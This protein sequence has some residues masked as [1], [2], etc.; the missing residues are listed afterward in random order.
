MNSTKEKYCIYSKG[1]FI[2]EKEIFTKEH[3]LI[4]FPCN[5]IF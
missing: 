5:K 3:Q 4:H 2:L 1:E